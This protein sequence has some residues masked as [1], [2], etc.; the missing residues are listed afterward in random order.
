MYDWAHDII[1]ESPTEHL[2]DRAGALRLLAEHRTGPH[3]YSRKIWT[4]LVFMLWHGIFVEGRIR[5]DVPEPV[6]P[7]RL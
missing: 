7:G 1:T 6:Y 5:P 2:I 3:D 4:L